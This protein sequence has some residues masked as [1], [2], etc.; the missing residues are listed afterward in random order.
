MAPAVTFVKCFERSIGD[1]PRDS[2]WIL[3]LDL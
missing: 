2:T 1:D 3:N